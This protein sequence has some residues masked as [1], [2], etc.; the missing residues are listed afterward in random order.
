MSRLDD[1]TLDAEFALCVTNL[2]TWMGSA[3]WTGSN[4][5]LFNAG[6]DGQIEAYKSAQY[7]LR[8]RVDAIRE[9]ADEAERNGMTDYAAGL[10]AAVALLGGGR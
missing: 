10:R 5:D 9:S 2:S 4:S 6:I 8:R 3:T 1:D 7:R